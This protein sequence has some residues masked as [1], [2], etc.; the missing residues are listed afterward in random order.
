[1]FDGEDLNVSIGEYSFLTIS[2]SFLQTHFF[3]LRFVESLLLFYFLMPPICIS[4]TLKTIT[5]CLAWL[6][7]NILPNGL[8]IFHLDLDKTP[9]QDHNFK[10]L[11]W[12]W[13]LSHRCFIRLRRRWNKTIIVTSYFRH[14]F[15]LCIQNFSSHITHII[16]SQ[17][18]SKVSTKMPARWIGTKFMVVTQMVWMEEGTCVALLVFTS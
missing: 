16:P 6:L 9:M 17:T 13:R 10:P 4:S 12:L 7:L 15:S 5:S 2:L 14:S 8:D 1:M 11:V 3:T 18:I